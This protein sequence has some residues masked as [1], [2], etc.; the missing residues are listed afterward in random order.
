[1]MGRV[2]HPGSAGPR[3]PPPL[4]VLIPLA[5]GSSAAARQRGGG[6]GALAHRHEVEQAAAWGPLHSMQRQ[7]PRRGLA[8]WAPGA[9]N[10]IETV[11]VGGPVRAGRAGGL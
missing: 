1:M 8:F 2:G 6:G 11:I 3:R 9:A 10:P 4:P 7:Q 5:C